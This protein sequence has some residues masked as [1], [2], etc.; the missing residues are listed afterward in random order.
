MTPEEASMVLRVGIRVL[1]AGVLFRAAFGKAKAP[2][3]AIESIR[4]VLRHKSGRSA[5]ILTCCVVIAE[6]IVGHAL[7]VGVALSQAAATVVL[8]MAAFS[9]AWLM[10]RRVGADGCGCFGGEGNLEGPLILVRNSLIALGAVITAIANSTGPHADA[11]RPV[12]SVAPDHLLFA[13]LLAVLGWLF[14]SLLT[15]LG[16]ILRSPEHEP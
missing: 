5:S 10:F 2:A 6:V 11:N 15:M 9:L 4:L 1:I 13:V 3:A 14:W 16:T 12:W 8:M 7:L